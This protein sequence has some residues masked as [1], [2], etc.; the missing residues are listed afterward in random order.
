MASEPIRDPVA[1]HLLCEPGG[2]WARKKTVPALM[3]LLSNK[4]ATA[5]AG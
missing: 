5:Q 4:S 3:N 2:D 1:D